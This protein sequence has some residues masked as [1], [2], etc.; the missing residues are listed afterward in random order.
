MTYDARPCVSRPCVTRICVTQVR[1]CIRIHAYAYAGMR[2]GQGTVVAR[3][4][5][6]AGT[7]AWSIDKRSMER[8]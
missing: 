4:G 3:V 1:V 6:E 2:I 8:I 7:K 5:D